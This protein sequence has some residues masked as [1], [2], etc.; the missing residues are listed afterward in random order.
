MEIT[1]TLGDNKKVTFNEQ[2]TKAVQLVNDWLDDRFSN[3]LFF[4]LRGFAGTGKSTI[5][6]YILDQHPHVSTV[7]SA[8]THQAVRV[9][10]NMTGRDCATIQG[11]CG[12]RP[13]TNLAKFSLK[14]MHFSQQAEP[15]I[16]N[17]QLIVIDES[18]QLGKDISNL[19]MKLALEYQVKILFIGDP[20]QLPPVNE[21]ESQ[22]FTDSRIKSTELT[23]VERQ[24][25][26]NPILPIC[27]YIRNNLNVDMRM[28]GGVFQSKV[29]ENKKVVF[30]TEVSSFL[31][32]AVDLFRTEPEFNKVITWT[33]KNVSNANAYIRKQLGKVDPLIES[34]DIVTAYSGNYQSDLIIN[35]ADYLVESTE[36]DSYFC[37]FTQLMYQVRY[38]NF[39]LVGTNLVDRIRILDPSSYDTYFQQVH[40]RLSSIES[41]IN[42]EVRRSKWSDYFMF[43]RQFLVMNDYTR[44]GLP[45]PKS[46]V[47]KTLDYGFAVTAHK[48]QGSTFKKVAVDYQDIRNNKRVVERNQLLY[49]AISRATDELHVNTSQ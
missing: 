36:S 10:S 28:P 19:I 49:V 40:L 18:S 41:E 45:F 26:G 48:A 27:D 9:I 46:L 47:P 17:Y 7:I 15:K 23:K 25:N 22:V 16:K 31:N 32:A 14:N 42:S 21:K 29:V 6:K 20:A 38:A 30:Y 43:T 34:G 37:E 11:I 5:V 12:L 44:P 4:T 13:Q 24:E 35:S 8:P 1:V 3:N 2:Q 39:R 33:N